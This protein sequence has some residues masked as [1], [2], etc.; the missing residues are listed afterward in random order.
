MDIDTAIRNL[1]ISESKTGGEALIM[2][3]KHRAEL[4]QAMSEAQSEGKGEPIEA[5]TT[6]FVDTARLNAAKTHAPHVVD[7]SA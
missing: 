2:I 3:A 6:Q 5:K 1:A 7:K 4:A